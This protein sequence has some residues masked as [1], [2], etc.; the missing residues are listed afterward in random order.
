MKVRLLKDKLR[1]CFKLC[2]KFKQPDL[3]IFIHFVTYQNCYFSRKIDITFAL[4][5]FTRTGGEASAATGEGTPER[6]SQSCKGEKER[7]GS[8]AK[9]GAR[10]GKTR[11]KRKG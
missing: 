1:A 8:Q 6:R 3:N 7:I 4:A 5:E 9:R 11:E 2:F 10:K